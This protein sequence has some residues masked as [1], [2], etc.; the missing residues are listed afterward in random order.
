M[1]LVLYLIWVI[2]TKQLRHHSTLHL[3]LEK[4]LFRKREANKIILGILYY[5][6][7]NGSE[8]ATFQGKSRIKVASV[9]LR[10]LK[11]SSKSISQTSSGDGKFT[12]VQERNIFIPKVTICMAVYS[13]QDRVPTSLIV[14]IQQQD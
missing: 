1:Q 3:C 7:I 13:T 14:L 8:A 5:V 6:N 12:S 11:T 4:C 9:T 10:L 2:S